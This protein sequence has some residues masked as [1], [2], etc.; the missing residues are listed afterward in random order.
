MTT[1]HKHSPAPWRFAID[2]EMD[3]GC[4]IPKVDAPLNFR[5]MGY[6]NNPSIIDANGE[7]VVG[8]SE[9]NVFDSP[10]Q[11]SNVALMLSA[12]E[13]LA[14]L[15]EIVE[16]TERYSESALSFGVINAKARAAIAKATGNAQ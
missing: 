15:E 1:Q 7:M 6:Y 16:L 11:P 10:N 4:N 8:C 2:G 5:G 12:P 14:A 13:L 3:D 9:Y